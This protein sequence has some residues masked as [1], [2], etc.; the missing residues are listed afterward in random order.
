[1]EITRSDSPKTNVEAE[2]NTLG[3][4]RDYDFDYDLI[5]L[6]RNNKITDMR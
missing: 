6:N 1:M 4:L 2:R 5:Q 3:I